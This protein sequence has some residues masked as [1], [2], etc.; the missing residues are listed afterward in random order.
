MR[1]LVAIIA[2]IFL[3]A[4]VSNALAGS[5]GLQRS[6]LRSQKAWVKWQKQQTEMWKKFDREM[7]A[8]AQQGEPSSRDRDSTNSKAF[9][10]QMRGKICLDRTR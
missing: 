8:I 9:T 7:N 6:F 1:V 5:A 3:A 4:P 10:G 2:L